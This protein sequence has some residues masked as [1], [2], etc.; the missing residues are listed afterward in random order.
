MSQFKTFTKLLAENTNTN[1][2]EPVIV[3]FSTALWLTLFPAITASPI[4]PA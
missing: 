3:K 4:T 1:D 2:A